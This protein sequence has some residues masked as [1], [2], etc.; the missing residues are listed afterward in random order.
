[1]SGAG[2]TGPDVAFAEF[3]AAGELRMQFCLDC[4]KQI[5]FPRSIC[6]GCGGGDLEWRPISPAGTV[7]ST[8]VIRRK[9]ERGGDYNVALIDLIEG[10]RMMS[11]VEGPDPHE[12]GIGMPVRAE[13]ATLESGPLV[14]FR[15]AGEGER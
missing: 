8:T 2:A 4:G 3:L 5:F 7:Y 14:I 10:A 12:V 9:A 13:I 6:P 11:R 15:P 1:M